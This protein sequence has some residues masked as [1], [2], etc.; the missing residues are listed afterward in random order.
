MALKADIN[1]TS[2]LFDAANKL[3]GSVAPSE[4][5]NYVL[6]LIFP[7]LSVVTL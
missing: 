5:K 2:D 7:S 6:P 4:Y 3:R 1:F